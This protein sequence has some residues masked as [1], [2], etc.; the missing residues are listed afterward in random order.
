VSGEP[1]VDDVAIA[2]FR[3]DGAVALRGLLDSSWIDALRDAADELL[4][5]CYDPTARMTSS[6]REGGT[7][8][9]QSSG[10]WR[11]SETFGRF[12]FESPIAGAS[13]ALMRSDTA[14]L[15]E[16]LFQ[17]RPAGSGGTS[18]H[19]DMPYWPM[20]GRQA[21][22]VWFTLEPV[23][24]YT[25][26]IHIVAGSHLHGDEEVK[27]HEEPGPQD[28]VLAFG[29]QPGD[30]IIFHPRALH[31][32]YG[33]SP[34]QPRRTFTIRFLGEDV[35]WRPARSYYHEWM[36]DTGL[37]EGDRLDHPGFPVMWPSRFARSMRQ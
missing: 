17:L 23:T 15:Y 35:R 12:L 24:P 21:T 37:R 26:A 7:A 29:C 31:T 2:R 20:T 5:D 25:G 1:I 13:A 4:E 14:R 10:K 3:L 22:N 33:S 6:N 27:R 28:H 34:D 8:V 11:E 16:D 36:S 9:L 32:G 18:W 19:R 30:V